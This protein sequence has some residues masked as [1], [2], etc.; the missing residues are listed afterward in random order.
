ML[1]KLTFV[2][3]CC[4]IHSLLLSQDLSVEVD[5]SWFTH[6]FVGS[7]FSDTTAFQISSRYNSK[8]AIEDIQQGKMR[9]LFHGGFGGVPDFNNPKDIQF[10]QTYNVEFYSQGCIR[11]PD[12][13]EEEYNRVIFSYLTALYGS[14]WRNSLREDAV[15]LNE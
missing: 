13:Q 12:D 6:Q 8:G 11:L 2:A 5:S 14:Y 3:F 7:S 4:F 15:G 9:I 10:Q 1:I